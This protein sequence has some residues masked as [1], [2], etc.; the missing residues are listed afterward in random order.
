MSRLDLLVRAPRAIT[1]ERG[2]GGGRGEQAV[3]VGVVGGRIA[4]VT[5]LAGADGL[6][7]ERTVDLADDEV[8]LPGLV[9]AHVHVN[10]PGRTEW[11]GFE[12][13]TRAAALG[14]ITTIVDMPLNA[15]PP[16]TTAD[17]LAVKADAAR[18][19]VH[20]DT[21]FF[22]GVVPG[23]T[24]DLAGLVAAG[25]FGAK[26]FTAPSGV[27][28]FPPVDAA[29][30]REAL[31]ELH[32]LGSVL[33]VHAEDPGVL[34][35]AAPTADGLD[36][37]AFSTFAATRP[38]EAEDAA[39]AAVADAVRATGGRAHVVHLA[40]AGAVAVLAAARAEGLAL[41]AETCPHYLTLDA[42]SVP[43]GA[44]AFKC[45]PPVRDLATQDALWAALAD[46]TLDSVVSD[47]SPCTPELKLLSTD[48]STGSGDFVAAWGGIA[49]VQLA[50]PATWTAARARGL[51][52][53]EVVRWMA[54]APAA[55]LGL[56]GRKGSVVVGADADLLVLAPEEEFVVDPA[57]LA[58][59]H[60]VTPYAGA[61]L[62]GVVR[63]TLLRG[64]VVDGV[65]PRGRLLSARGAG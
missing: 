56:G 29:Q 19:R 50:L 33:L 5:D 59:R 64:V 38:P 18:G 14:G 53:A 52:L 46:G 1:G 10:E 49:S 20:V 31:G 57:R 61:R 41:T 25:V 34:D 11:E 32:R 23:N 37:R 15:V 3:A 30:L 65:T 43:D 42:G 8:L 62:R 58:H 36:P 21:G 54:A 28:E 26:C 39:V 16:T 63:S 22:G 55:R 12:T 4:V 44:T 51:P 40:S 13:A 2:P 9:D 48:S 27:E 47:H 6:D 45:C 35:A 24:P 17:N 7:A 60:P